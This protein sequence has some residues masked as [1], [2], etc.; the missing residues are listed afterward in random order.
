[1]KN[2][3][4]LLW[5]ILILNSCSG[6]SNDLVRA[7][8]KGEVYSI[9]EHQFSARYREGEWEAGSPS[10]FGHRIINYDRDGLYLESIILN[11][12]GD[13]AGIT[14]SRR[15]NGE[16]VEEILF[17]GYS[18]GTSKTLFERIS[19]EQVNF[20]LWD[21]DKLFFEGANFYDSKGRI[22]RQHTVENDREVINYFEYNKGLLVKNYQED[23][24]GIRIYTQQYEYKSFDEKGNWTKKLVYV[25]EDKITPRLVITRIYSYY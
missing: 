4:I 13:T 6:G 16:L 3:F 20:E 23:L 1:M 22:E 11:E 7:G 2:I 5:I 15:E 18:N 21:G 19:K 24:S 8:L 12:R 14:R 10:S 17:S 9:L 25:G